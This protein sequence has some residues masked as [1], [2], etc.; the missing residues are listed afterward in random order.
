MVATAAD[1]VPWTKPDELEYD[2]EKDP[3][4]LIGFL[5]NEKTQFVMCDG[6]VLRT[7]S[8]AKFPPRRRRYTRPLPTAAAKYSAKTSRRAGA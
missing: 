8:K 6:S 7:Y 5:L 1:A 4:K 3:T 2:A